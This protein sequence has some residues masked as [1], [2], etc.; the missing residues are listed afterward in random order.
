MHLLII[1]KG[2]T[3]DEDVYLVEHMGPFGCPCYMAWM[4]DDS[5]L[6]LHSV[7][8]MANRFGLRSLGWKSPTPHGCPG[9]WS[10]SARNSYLCVGSTQ[11]QSHHE[12][13][14]GI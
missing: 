5:L 1:P 9:H 4:V 13:F 8:R 12:D 10:E 6:H 2:G 11:V 14:R 3:E 7:L